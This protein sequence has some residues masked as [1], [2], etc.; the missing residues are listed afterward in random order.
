MVTICSKHNEEAQRAES[1]SCGG[2]SFDG[3]AGEG[4]STKTSLSGGTFPEESE[5]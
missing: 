3:E 1:L 5:Q 2:P 4:V